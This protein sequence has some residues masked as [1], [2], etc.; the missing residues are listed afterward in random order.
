MVDTFEGEMLDG[1]YEY[2]WS[3]IVT[4]FAPLRAYHWLRLFSHWARW[5]SP[6]ALRVYR[7]QRF[8][9]SCSF[10][11]RYELRKR[12]IRISLLLFLGSTIFFGA[13]LRISEMTYRPK[14]GSGSALD[15]SDFFN[16]IWVAAVTMTTVGYGDGYPS[17]HYGRAISVAACCLAMGL[18]SLLI[19]ASS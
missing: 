3:S 19:V 4:L 10:W 17:T 7:E 2:S 13:A 6:E 1:A 9:P 14:D 18:T 12:P 8:H 5:N 11:V 16:V 15:F